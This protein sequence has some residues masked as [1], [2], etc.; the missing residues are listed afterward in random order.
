MIPILDYE[1]YYCSCE[2]DTMTRPLLL[3]EILQKGEL[4]TQQTGTV[5]IHSF[6]M[7]YSRYTKRDFT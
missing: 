1:V 7:K 3:S 4:N 5:V 6:I 2:G